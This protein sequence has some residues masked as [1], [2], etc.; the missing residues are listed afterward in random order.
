[1][2]RIFF[3]PEDRRRLRGWNERPI[4]DVDR[5]LFVNCGQ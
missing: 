3:A 1:M 5:R 2:F 4:P